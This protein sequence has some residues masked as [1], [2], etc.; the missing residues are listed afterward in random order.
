MR[1]K[2][3]PLKSSHR[4]QSSTLDNPYF[5]KSKNQF[6]QMGYVGGLP[7]MS[8][9]VRQN[10]AKTKVR[11]SFNVDKASSPFTESFYM[12]HSSNT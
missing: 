9:S 2:L 1:A 11:A 10:M 4:S 6:K 5:K 12:P 7:A 3:A 8:L